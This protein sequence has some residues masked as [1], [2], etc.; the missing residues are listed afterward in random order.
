MAWGF[1]FCCFVLCV[2]VC[3]VVVFLLFFFLKGNHCQHLYG[4]APNYKQDLMAMFKEK[5]GFSP[6]LQKA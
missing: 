6:T 1:L 3:L 4:I 5:I 2:C